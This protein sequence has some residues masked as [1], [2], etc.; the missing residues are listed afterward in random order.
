MLRQIKLVLIMI[1]YKNSSVNQFFLN[2]SGFS[3][4]YQKYDLSDNV[5]GT[6]QIIFEVPTTVNGS[7]R[8]LINMLNLF[9]KY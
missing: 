9:L 2:D 8:M 3:G 7:T 4:N 5:A 6:I 1:L